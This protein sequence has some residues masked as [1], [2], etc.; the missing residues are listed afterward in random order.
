MG[1][2]LQLLALQAIPRLAQRFNVELEEFST[3]TD[4]YGATPEE[5]QKAFENCGSCSIVFSKS[6]TFHGVMYI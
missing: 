5:F 4:L 6:F 1:A 2:N 3:F